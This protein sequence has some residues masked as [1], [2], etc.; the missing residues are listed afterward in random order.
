MTR[1]PPNIFDPIRSADEDSASFAVFE[2][3]RVR[4]PS[5][6]DVSSSCLSEEA[7]QLIVLLLR[8]RASHC[9]LFHM[10]WVSD[11]SLMSYS[12]HNERS[13]TRTQLKLMLIET[14]THVPIMPHIPLG[15]IYLPCKQLCYL[16]TEMIS[17]GIRLKHE[18]TKEPFSRKLFKQTY[19]L[20]DL[21]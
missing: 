1:K 8:S 13:L 12:P 19:R 15:A 3:R 11:L 21:L 14:H 7:L 4:L 10:L 2:Q 6:T 17:G 20:K 16:K 9:D 18:R 5:S